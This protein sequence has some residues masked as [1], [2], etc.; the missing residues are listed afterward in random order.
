MII[1]CFFCLFFFSYG[2]SFANSIILTCVV[3]VQHKW[4]PGVRWYV[5]GVFDHCLTRASVW[6]TWE[7]IWQ[8]VQ[9]VWSNNVRD[10]MT[11]ESMDGK[12]RD[13]RCASVNKA[14]ARALRFKGAAASFVSQLS[15][16]FKFSIMLWSVVRLFIESSPILTD[17]NAFYKRLL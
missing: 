7:I 2:L 17:L 12:F 9:S 3:H 6:N 8:A 4:S 13:E 16:Y 15:I 14:I 5:L 11:A 1:M 10:C